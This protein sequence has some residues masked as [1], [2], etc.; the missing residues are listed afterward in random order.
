MSKSPIQSYQDLQV[1][2]EGMNLAEA[3][4]FV[5]KSFP[6]EE[7]YGMTSQIRRAAVSIP[8]NI[9]EGYGRRSRGE[10]LQFLYIAQG[11]LK[12]L[13]THLILSKRIKLA[14]IPTIDPVLAQCQ[15]VGRLLQG[16][17]RSLEN[18]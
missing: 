14:E 18:K 4:Y 16:L 5:T 15:L 13:E 8:A 7:T 1:W 10:Y 12:E 9:A 11:S 2:Q 3:C 6:K 17:I